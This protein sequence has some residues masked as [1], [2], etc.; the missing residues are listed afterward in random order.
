MS[1]VRYDSHGA[2]E[3]R[4]I[5]KQDRRVRK[6]RNQKFR[7]LGVCVS[8]FALALGL[9]GFSTTPTPATESSGMRAVASSLRSATIAAR[10][11]V[12]PDVCLGCHGPFAKLASAPAEFVTEDGKKINPH[13]YIPHDK[14]EIPACTNCHDPHPV[15]LTSREDLS[16]PD[17]DYCYN[18]C[19]HRRNFTPCKTCH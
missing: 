9:C 11:E 7:H 4:V 10:A 8:V 18:T 6:P 13:V 5:G 17:V 15:P 16:K 12:S 14:R 3:L 1:H 2:I 19:H